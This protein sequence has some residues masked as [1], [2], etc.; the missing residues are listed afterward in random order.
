MVN[1][2]FITEAFIYKLVY[3]DISDAL[4]S[5][6]CCYGQHQNIILFIIIITIIIITIIIIILDKIWASI[7]C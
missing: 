1:L 7:I 5:N 6:S 2:S 4:F 3:M